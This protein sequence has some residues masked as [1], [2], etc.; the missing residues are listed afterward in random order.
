MLIYLPLAGLIT[1]FLSFFTVESRIAN[2]GLGWLA[3]IVVA[4]LPLAASVGLE[5]F[6]LVE[7]LRQATRPRQAVSV[8]LGADMALVRG[9]LAVWVRAWKGDTVVDAVGADFSSPQPRLIYAPK[10]SFD[11][12]RGVI[13]IGSRAFPATLSPPH[14]IE[15]LPEA[16]SLSPWWIWDRLADQNGL[17]P[18]QAMAMALGFGLLAAGLRFLAR[19]TS[20]TLAN[21]FLVAAGLLGV[22]VLDAF[23][24]RPEIES[25]AAP[26]L[27][28]LGL[29]LPYPLFVAFFEAALGI[30]A[31][32]VDSL[33]PG[34]HARH[35]NA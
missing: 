19:M 26:L 7:E 4:L 2:R 5:R 13:F 20:W 32:L 25:F 27:G 9:P 23:L 35:F 16:G 33:R 3:L 12:S 11:R 14:Q 34:A 31:G 8:P 21:A 10:A 28:R 18:L 30:L 22:L 6:P 24:A 15:L 17:P 1:L 29:R